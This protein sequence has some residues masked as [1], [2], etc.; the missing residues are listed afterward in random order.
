MAK[1]VF[2]AV[3]TE[4]GND[5]YSVHFPDVN[6][7]YTCGDSLVDAMEMAEDALTMMLASAEK[8]GTP[9]PTATPIRQVA[10]NDGSFVTLILCDTEGYEFTE[11]EAT[12]RIRDA[13]AKSGLT[14]A[15]L[16]QQS[17]IPADVIESIETKEWGTVA[18]AIKL[19]KVLNV[20]LS[21]ICEQEDEYDE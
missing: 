2:P 17:G 8:D 7:C 16:S 4:E 18:N 13:R 3:F 21:E 1:Y 9:I 15:E 14:I 10:V 20:E 11:C 19:S 12:I 5:H 6:G